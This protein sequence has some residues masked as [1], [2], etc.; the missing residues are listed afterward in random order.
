MGCYGTLMAMRPQALVVQVADAATSG[1]GCR[2]VTVVATVQLPWCCANSCCTWYDGIPYAL[3]HTATAQV[4]HVDHLKLST[5]RQTST[6]GSCSAGGRV[7]YTP[8]AGT[9]T[10]MPRLWLSNTIRLVG[11][12]QECVFT[13]R[14]AYAAISTTCQ[15]NDATRDQDTSSVCQQLC[16]HECDLLIA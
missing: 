11:Q 1:S 9:E 13:S 2:A 12:P 8:H 14:G 6:P 7:F 3:Q 10:A 5:C 4:S 16:A 15:T